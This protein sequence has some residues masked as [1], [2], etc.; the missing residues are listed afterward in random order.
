MANG[1][2]KIVIKH[3]V[4]SKIRA[5]AD[6]AREE[7]SAMGT[8]RVYNNVIY[9]DDVFLFNQMVTGTSTEICQED[10]SRFVYECIKLG[11]DPSSLKFWWHSHAN[12]DVFWSTTDASTINQL[13]K[14]WMVSIVSN[15]QDKFKLRLDIFSPIRICLDDLPYTVEYDKSN[16]ASIMAE[17]NAKVH[18]PSYGRII[19]DFFATGS[20]RDWSDQRSFIPMPGDPKTVVMTEPR[21]PRGSAIPRYTV[22]KTVFT[23]LWEFF[24]GESRFKSVEINKLEPVSTPPKPPTPTP[25]AETTKPMEPVKP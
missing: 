7:I 2:P 25:A 20:E 5:Y 13:S 1:L 15:K 18:T 11:L 19:S 21:K 3:Q 4:Y 8:V 22:N 24:F 14:E 6:L 10:L 23:K 9:I 16:N 12:M 17:I